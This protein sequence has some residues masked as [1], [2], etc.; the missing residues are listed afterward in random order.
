MTE[1]SRSKANVPSRPGL[2]QAKGTEAG[3]WVPYEG[4]LLQGL[5]DSDE[6]SAYLEAAHEDG[7]EAVLRLA[8]S[9]VE[10]ARGLAK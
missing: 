4:V 3:P 7:D 2:S 6:A 9:Q 1:Q 5:R 8:L 10:K